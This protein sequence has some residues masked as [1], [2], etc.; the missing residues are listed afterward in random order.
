MKLLE[1]QCP[2]CG[3]NDSLPDMTS[4]MPLVLTCPDCQTPFLNYHEKCFTL[5]KK[6]VHQLFK[7]GNPKKLN[8]YFWSV[9]EK[10]E[11]EPANMHDTAHA[12]ASTRPVRTEPINKEDIIDLKITLETKST[13]DDFLESI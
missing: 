13:I 7:E 6:K 9:I 10:M 1:I 11:K 2:I 3:R 8:N 4:E 12:I 5:N